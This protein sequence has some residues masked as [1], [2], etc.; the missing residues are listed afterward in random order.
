M[1][2]ATDRAVEGNGVPG[3]ALALLEHID[4]GIAA[5][6]AEGRL[7]LANGAARREFESR[8]A[9]LLEAGK[10]RCPDEGAPDFL[11]AVQDAAL[12]QRSSLLCAGVGD[13]RLMLAVMPVSVAPAQPP[14]VLLMLGRRSLCSALGL[15]MLAIRHGLT[16]TERRVLKH[17]IDGR[18]ARTIA[19]EHGVALS[20]V[21]TQIQS[22]RHKLGARNIDALLL[23]A[24]QVPPVSAPY[25]SR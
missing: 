9:L 7:L 15:E 21:R 17:L 23:R 14:A 12:R 6:D 19:E 1:T 18:P 8:R 22:L 2:T 24:A 16:L 25:T 5:C 10:V 20:T 4:G 11:A 3:L 13:S